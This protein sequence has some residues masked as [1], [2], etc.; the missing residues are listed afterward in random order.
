MSELVRFS[1]TMPETMMQALDAYTARRGCARNRSEA[2]R[3]LVREALVDEQVEDTLA[4]V[5]GTLTI[6]FDHHQRDLRD[7]LDDIQHEHCANIVSTTHVHLDEG[8]C[9]EVTIMRGPSWIVRTLANTILGTKGVLHGQL[10]VTTVGDP[11]GHGGHDA[12]HPVHDH[13]E[14]HTHTDVHGHVYTHTH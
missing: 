5:V 4:E 14:P 9:L 2:I 3:D 10:V 13:G 1:I 7:K 8:A 11:A 12:G 6:V